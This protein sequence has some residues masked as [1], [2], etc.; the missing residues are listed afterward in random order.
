MSL[1][2]QV[3]QNV[4]CRCFARRCRKKNCSLKLDNLPGP[5]ILIYMDREEAPMGSPGEKKCDYIFIGYG[6]TC[7]WV[8]P[9]ELKRGKLKTSEVVPQLQAGAQIAEQIVPRQ[10]QT[11]FRPIA[12]HGGELHPDE[13]KRLR[14][15][16]INFHKIRERVR[17]VRSG[18]S[19]VSEL[20]KA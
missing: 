15:I 7:D 9:L 17:A 3:R 1:V 10:A 20:K 12:V 4:D 13:Y 11:Q 14:G 18:K 6:D 8:A 16:R 5:F 2:S 19:L